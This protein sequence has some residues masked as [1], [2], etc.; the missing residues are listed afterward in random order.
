ML[1]VC[2]EIERFL[3]IKCVFVI[4]KVIIL[5]MFYNKQ[6]VDKISYTKWGHILINYQ[7][8]FKREL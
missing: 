1:S 6:M 4:L 8:P 3:Q 7:L 5:I 2:L